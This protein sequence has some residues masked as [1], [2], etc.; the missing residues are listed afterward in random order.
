V[1]TLIVT[2][3]SFLILDSTAK[4]ITFSVGVVMDL[5]VL[6]AAAKDLLTSARS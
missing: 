5:G 1:I 6:I 3:L 4:W 2:G